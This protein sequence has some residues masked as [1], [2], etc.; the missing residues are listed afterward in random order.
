MVLEKGR[1]CVLDNIGIE[2]IGDMLRRVHYDAVMDAVMM[3]IT[4]MPKNSNRSQQQLLFITQ[5]LLR[6]TVITIPTLSILQ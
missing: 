6:S 1:E 3:L 5:T 2:V 4:V